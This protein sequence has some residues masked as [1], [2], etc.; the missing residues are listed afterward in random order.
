MASSNRQ[1]T[2]SKGIPPLLSVLEFVCN[3]GL[4]DAFQVLSL[5]HN[6]QDFIKEEPKLFVLFHITRIKHWVEMHLRL[7]QNSL[8]TDKL[9]QMLQSLCYLIPKYQPDAIK[10]YTINCNKNDKNDKNKLIDTSYS[11]IFYK[12]H[13]EIKIQTILTCNKST[14]IK[15]NLLA[16]N[17]K[18]NL[19]TNDPLNFRHIDLKQDIQNNKD[20]EFE[21]LEIIETLGAFCKK[22]KS[23]NNANSSTSKLQKFIENHSFNKFKTELYDFLAD[24]KSIYCNQMIDLVYNTSLHLDKNAKENAKKYD[25]KS[26]E[27]YLSQMQYYSKPKPKPKPKPNPPP[28]THQILEISK[29]NNKPMTTSKAKSYKISDYKIGMLVKV[30]QNNKNKTTNNNAEYIWRTAKIIQTKKSRITVEL[31]DGASSRTAHH[32][33]KDISRIKPMEIEKEIQDLISSDDEDNDIIMINNDDN[34][35]NVP[36]KKN[37]TAI[38]TA[39]GLRRSKRVNRSSN[40]SVQ[41][42]NYERGRRFWEQP[43]DDALRAGI[44]KY[45]HLLD[46]KKKGVKGIWSKIKEDDEFAPKLTHRTPKMMYDRYRVYVKKGTVP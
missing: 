16:N 46:I 23:K 12:L 29:N 14:D 19:N 20:I 42:S 45:K 24:I 33:I 3:H 11:S 31:Q 13:Q 7:P 37:H 8:L 30:R 26:R 27:Q 39:F 5:E 25:N 10:R 36:N 4:Y 28:A 15:H 40:L 2:K 6:I 38:G 9:D 41:S 34:K 35:E 32:H 18:V 44:I 17:L 22:D 21:I 43:E 1:A